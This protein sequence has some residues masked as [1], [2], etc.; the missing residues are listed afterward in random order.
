ME[1]ELRQ[2]TVAQ[3]VKGFVYNE[4]EAK[5][6]YG[7]DGDLVIPMTACDDGENPGHEASR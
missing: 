2:Y 3:V 4:L 5:G 6:L 1:T 7:L